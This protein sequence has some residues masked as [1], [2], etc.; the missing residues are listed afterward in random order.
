MYE[1]ILESIGRRIELTEDEQQYFTSLL[2]VRTVRKRQFLLQEGDVCRYEYFVNKGCLRAYVVDAKGVERVLQFA[3]E[4]WWIGDM[5]SFIDQKPARLAIDALEDSEVYCIDKAGWTAL[6]ERVPKFERFFRM[7]LE[8]AFITLQERVTS[9]LSATAEE[10]YG[11]FQER[12]P[13]FEQRLPQHQIASYL[14][15]TP[16]SLSRIRKQRM[17]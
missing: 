17:K 16:E 2:Q 15:I 3:I 4:D 12:Y 11:Q 7:L 6:L 13:Q 8:R 9:A 14:G 10:R 1:R 5:Q